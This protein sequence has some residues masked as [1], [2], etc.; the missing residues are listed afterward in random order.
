MQAPSDSPRPRGRPRGFETHDALEAAMR[1][2]WAAGY[3]GASVD[4]L[5]RETAMPRA[6][7]YHD[8]GGKERLFL[9][10]VAHYVDTRIGPVAQALGPKGT[11]AEDLTAFFSAVIA[12]ATGDT[13]TPGCLISCVLADA[14]GT[15]ETFRAELEDRFQALEDRIAARLVH[16]GEPRHD[17]RTAARAAM[18]A[19]VARGLMLRARSGAGADSLTGIAAVT[20]DSVARGA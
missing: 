11:L 6:S 16:D 17:P 14:A 7:L 5:C 19:A 2:F 12:L 3:D 9:A 20:V 4:R 18:L 15:S 10:A 13:R 1:V 8:Y